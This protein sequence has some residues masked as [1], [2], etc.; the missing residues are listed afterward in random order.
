MGR[1]QL[2]VVAGLAAVICGCAT[3]RVPT[4]LLYASA[5]STGTRLTVTVGSCRGNPELAHAAETTT[6]VR[7]RVISDAESG[8]SLGCAHALEVRLLTP[9]DDRVRIDDSTGDQVEVR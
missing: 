3:E 4:A 9:L 5:D 7:V 8:D 2:L 1:R 6:E